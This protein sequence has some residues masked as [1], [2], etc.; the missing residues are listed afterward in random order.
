VSYNIDSVDTPV[1]D[2]WMTAR[3]IVLLHDEHARQCGRWIRACILGVALLMACSKKNPQIADEWQPSYVI[4]YP[5]GCSLAV[6]HDDRP[7]VMDSRIMYRTM[8]IDDAGVPIYLN[9]NSCWNPLP[10]TGAP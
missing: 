2:A 5:N 10:N 4:R 6:W 3:D 9:D 8:F 1:L 7:E